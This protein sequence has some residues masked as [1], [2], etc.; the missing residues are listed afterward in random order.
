MDLLTRHG[1]DM[2]RQQDFPVEVEKE[3]LLSTSMLMV[4]AAED[5]DLSK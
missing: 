5:M 2:K 3:S 1:L 4:A